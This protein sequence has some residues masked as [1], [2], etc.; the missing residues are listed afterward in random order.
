MSLFST[1]SLSS[2][3]RGT[4]L[5]TKH[6]CHISRDKALPNVSTASSF[7]CH[8]FSHVGVRAPI[9]IKTLLVIQEFTMR[10]DLDALSMEHHSNFLVTWMTFFSVYDNGW[11]DFIELLLVFK[12]LLL[13]LIQYSSICQDVIGLESLPLMALSKF[14]NDLTKRLLPFWM[15]KK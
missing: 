9:S 5:D 2:N 7:R 1:T 6:L 12:H 15:S 13:T 8:S 11:V 10:T 14:F 3:S 4:S